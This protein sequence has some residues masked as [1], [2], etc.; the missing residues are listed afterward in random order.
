MR[1]KVC[2]DYKITSSMLGKWIRDQDTIRQKVASKRTRLLKQ[3]G[4]RPPRFPRAEAELAT[5]FKERRSLGRR[6]SERWFFT[7]MAQLVRDMYPGTPFTA[8][9]GWLFRC[10]HRLGVSH[11]AKSN[12]KRSAAAD[13]VP[14]VREWLGRYRHM[15]SIPLNKSMQMDPIWGRFPPPLRFNCDQVSTGMM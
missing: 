4:T 2:K 7:T 14:A 12:C 8:S 9:R 3:G 15:L 13:R 11:R 6:V 1:E 10:C 5:R